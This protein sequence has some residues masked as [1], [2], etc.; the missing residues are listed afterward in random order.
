MACSEQN[1]EMFVFYGQG[2]GQ[3]QRQRQT[4]TE[5]AEKELRKTENIRQ[6]RKA[7]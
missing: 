5:S 7:E 4:E 6:S 3:G 1:I 2:Q